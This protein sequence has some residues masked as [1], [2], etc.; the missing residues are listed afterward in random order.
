MRHNPGM[1]RPRGGTGA[2]IQTL[3][4]LVQSLGGTILTE[5]Q[6]EKVLV[7]NDR[8][9]GVRVAGGTEY[10]AS[11]GVI[12]N[13]DAKRLFLHMMDSSDVRDADPNLQERLERRIINN[14]ETILKIDCALSE[15]LKFE[16]YN[17]QD[18]YLIGSV[19]I[20]DSFKHVEFAH[21]LPNV[22]QIP[23]ADPSMY[24]VVP[25]MLDPSMAPE[26]KHTLWIE[27]FAPY[28]IDKAEGTGLHDTGWTNELKERVADRVIDK[29][30][31]YAPNVKNAI[32]ARQV[33]SPAELGERLGALKGN[34]YHIDMSL[35]QMMFFRPLP[36]LANYK[37]PIEGLFLTGAGTH[38]GGSISGMPGRNCAR[39]FL[40]EQQPLAQ[41]LKEGLESLKDTA[42]SVF[43]IS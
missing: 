7:D 24:A 1:A 6:V 23:D 4:N 22:G 21:S 42:Q 28:Q 34:Y 31:E 10:R 20:A 8:V 5:Q 25:T 38:P 9:V 2:L 36:E 27:F 33:E 15:P 11:R 37:T 3:V 14:N 40:H 26:G 12:S 29:L 19:L 41:T 39:I 17:H 18:E 43:G 13:I 16:R 35:E 30:A 32:I